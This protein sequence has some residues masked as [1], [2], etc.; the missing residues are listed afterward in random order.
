MSETSRTAIFF[1]LLVCLAKCLA[2][3]C[4]QQS[5]V[6]KPEKKETKLVLTSTV[7]VPFTFLMFHSCLHA[8]LFIRFSLEKVAQ[9]NSKALEHVKKLL[10]L[11]HRALSH[12]K[13]CFPSCHFLQHLSVENANWRATLR[14]VWYGTMQSHY[15]I[16]A[17]RFWLLRVARAKKKRA[18]RFI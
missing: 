17:L 7:V 3:Q 1:L 5:V 2:S 9:V 10:S 4:T 13:F 8:W 16:A 18:T 12:V 14:R 11:L 6:K 15:W